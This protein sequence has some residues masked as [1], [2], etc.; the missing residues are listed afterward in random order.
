MCIF[1]CKYMYICV[2]LYNIKDENGN[3]IQG[4]MI[5]LVSTRGFNSIL[6]C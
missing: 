6:T 3:V 5:T 4:H 1:I 2:C